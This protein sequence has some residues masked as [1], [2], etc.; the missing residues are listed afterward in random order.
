MLALV[1][2]MPDLL[3]GT[4]QQALCQIV[5][6]DTDFKHSQDLLFSSAN[7]KPFHAIYDSLRL[8]SVL[9]DKLCIALFQTSSDYDSTAVRH[10]SSH[11]LRSTP[12]DIFA[13]VTMMPVG[14]DG[15]DYPG[16]F[17]ATIHLKAF[18]PIYFDIS[19]IRG[20]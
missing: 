8:I 3:V 17:T 7:R 2:C 9:V 1:D 11:H 10:F 4:Y 14:C 15:D 18:T 16:R 6:R 13:L 12:A 5:F 19:R 20:R